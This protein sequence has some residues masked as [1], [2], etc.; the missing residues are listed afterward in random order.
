[1]I[2]LM[3]KKNK[4]EVGSTQ[5]INLQAHRDK[6]TAEDNYTFIRHCHYKRD[7]QKRELHFKHNTLYDEDSMTYKGFCTPYYANCITYKEDN[8]VYNQQ[9]T[10][11]YHDCTLYDGHCT[12]YCQHCTAYY[13]CYTP[14]YWLNTLYYWHC[15]PYN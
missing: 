4:L 3:N 8:I 15:T 10:A 11:Y 2:M 1:M 5:N 12:T 13:W 6:R 7:N 14:S 9:H